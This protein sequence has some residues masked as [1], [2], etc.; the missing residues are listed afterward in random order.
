MSPFCACRRLDCQAVFFPV[1]IEESSQLALIISSDQDHYHDLNQ[2]LF[3]ANGFNSLMS[4]LNTTE[5]RGSKDNKN[6]RVCNRASIFSF[7]KIQI[8][9]H[10]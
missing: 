7:C 5:S 2:N 3:V 8:L 6:T 10:F 9:A 4:H 1:N